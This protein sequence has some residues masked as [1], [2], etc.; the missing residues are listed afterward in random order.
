MLHTKLKDATLLANNVLWF[1]LLVQNL[2]QTI[3]QILLSSP[4]ELGKNIFLF[5][6]N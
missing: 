3:N 1:T 6:W 5:N 2:P 4:K